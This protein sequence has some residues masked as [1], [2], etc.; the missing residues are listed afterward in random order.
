MLHAERISSFL[1]CNAQ[2]PDQLQALRPVDSAVRI[3]RCLE[4]GSTAENRSAPYI[5]TFWER[6]MRCLD[7]LRTKRFEQRDSVP[8]DFGQRIQYGAR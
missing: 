1:V 7:I 5:E 2:H 8:L 4:Q 6:F 3:H